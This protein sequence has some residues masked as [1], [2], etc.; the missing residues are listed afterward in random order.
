MT[1]EGGYRAD[2]LDAALERE[3]SAT[4]VASA[5]IT[6]LRHL[7]V[8]GARRGLFTAYDLYDIYAPIDAAL[9]EPA[10]FDNEAAAHWEFALDEAVAYALRGAEA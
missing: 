6:G 3:Q 5:A 9:S 10:L 7:I 1:S 4:L 2:A 8:L